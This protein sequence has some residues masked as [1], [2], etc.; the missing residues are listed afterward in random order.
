[1]VKVGEKYELMEVMSHTVNKGESRE[2]LY[3]GSFMNHSCEP[4]SVVSQ[5]GGTVTLMSTRQIEAGEEVTYDYSV[6]DTMSD[7]QDFACLCKS[8]HCRGMVEGRKKEKTNNIKIEA[9]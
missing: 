6:F 2:F 3:F 1:M 9:Q 7:A 5:E 4:N 8:T